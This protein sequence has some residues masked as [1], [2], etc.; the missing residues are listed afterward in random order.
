MKMW[1]TRTLCIFITVAAEVVT[2]I[3]L[4][5]HVPYF[6][7]FRPSF[8]LAS[9]HTHTP[10]SSTLPLLPPPLPLP[11]PTNAIMCNQF[12]IR[13]FPSHNFF[14]SV[15]YRKRT[16]RKTQTHIRTYTHTLTN[17]HRH[18]HKHKYICQNMEREIS[19]WKSKTELFRIFKMFNDHCCNRNSKNNKNQKIKPFL[20]PLNFFFFFLFFLNINA[21]KS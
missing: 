1:K 10:P 15:H 3:F 7:T 18:R 13:N 17:R 14:Y 2:T 12:L 19:K 16:N 21:F 20:F 9:L 4:L 6:V 11:P 5:L 8:Q